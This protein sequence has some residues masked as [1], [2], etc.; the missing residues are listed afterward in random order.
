MIE[1]GVSI[2]RYQDGFLHQKVVLM[3]DQIASIGSVNF[4]NRSFAINFEITLWFADQQTIANVETMLVEDFKLCR[5]VDMTEVKGRSLTMRFL[6]QAA[7]LFSPL[8]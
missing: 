2:Y 7:R 8:L 3:D 5:Q 1:H 6:T 4:D